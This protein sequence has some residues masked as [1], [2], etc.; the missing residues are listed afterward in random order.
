MKLVSWNVFNDNDDPDAVRG[1]LA[2]CGADVIALQEASETHLSILNDLGGYRLFVA[3]DFVEDGA[4]FHLAV[5]S[6]LPATDHQIVTHNPERAISD[7]IQGRRKKWIEG[8]DSHAVTL[9]IGGADVRLVNLHL[10][11]GVPP[12]HRLRDLEAAAA[13]IDDAA[14][15]VICGDFN[16]FARP[17]LNLLGGWIFG[18]GLAEIGA[19][20]RRRLDRFAT[21][22]GLARVFDRAVTFPRYRL[23][24]DHILVRGL[25][26]RRARVE[27]GTY[28]SDHRPLI[29]DLGV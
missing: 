28:G 1:F 13:H 29:A 8:L 23:H 4:L 21:A 25:T 6:R 5:A 14:H 16:M 3:E 7:S 2:G 24:L 19:N 12:V 15:A 22:H 18:V 26:A 10:P 11:C 17:I 20:E 9:D 27:P